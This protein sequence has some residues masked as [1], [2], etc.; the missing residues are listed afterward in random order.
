MLCIAGTGLLWWTYFDIKKKL[1]GTNP[2]TLLEE[3]VRNEKFFY[4]LAI[5]ASIITVSF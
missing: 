2:E 1:D 4:V 3:S 5:V